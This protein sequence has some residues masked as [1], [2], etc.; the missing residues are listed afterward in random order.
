MASEIKLEGWKE[1]QAK[2]SDLPNDV[3]E[4]ADGFV[5]SAANQWAEMA[6]NDAPVDKGFLRKEIHAV[7]KGNMEAEVVSPKEYSAY[8]EWGTGSRVSVPAGL[9]EYALQFKGTRVTIGRYPHPF[10]FIQKPIIEKELL[11]NLKKLLETPR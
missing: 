7:E 8:V 10:F 2:L 1:F 3:I 9:K 5:V 4:Q 11:A 6:I